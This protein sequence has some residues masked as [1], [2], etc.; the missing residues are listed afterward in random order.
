MPARS[1]AVAVISSV[2]TESVAP[3]ERVEFWEDYNRRALVGLTC[4]SYAEQG[5][6]AEQTNIAFGGLRIAEILGNAH[7]IERSRR[8]CRAMP[9]D[10]VFASLVLGGDAVFFSGDGVY[11]VAVGS[12]VLYETERPYLFAFASPMRMVL[13]DIP[14]SVFTERCRSGG[15]PAPQVIGPRSPAEAAAASA[16]RSVA[17]ALVTRR[18]LPGG[19]DPET[20]VLELVRA[21]AAQRFEGHRGQLAAVQDYIERHL[22]DPALCT[23]SVAAAAGISPRQLRRIFEAAGTSPARYILRRRL[24]RTHAQLT[25]AGDTH[26]ADRSSN[27]IADIGYRCGFASQ[28]HFTRVYREHFGQTPGEARSHPTTP[29]P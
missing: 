15:L 23:E 26:R 5:L 19:D 12:L 18:A 28:S 20:T 1:S 10:S 2:S 3:H 22:S 14:R 7:A 29:R 27:T 21:L 17:Y 8:T 4:S 25:A 24:E 11:P 9:K 13:V 6:V 16:L